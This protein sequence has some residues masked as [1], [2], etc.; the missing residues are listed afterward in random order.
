VLRHEIIADVVQAVQASPS[1]VPL[2]VLADRAVRSIG[3]DRTVATS[4]AGAGSFRDLLAQSL[5]DDLRL[6]DQPPYLV[7]DTR[8]HLQVTRAAPLPEMPDTREMREMAPSRTVAPPS[9]PPAAVRGGF[10][11]AVG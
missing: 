7:I 6:S 4:W 11:D 2:E 10:A 8:R 3:H 5:P 1:P 9:P